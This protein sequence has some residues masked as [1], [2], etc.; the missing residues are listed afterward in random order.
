MT[1]IS[2][3]IVF[4]LMGL[5]GMV[6]WLHEFLIV[7]AGFGPICFLLGGVM[8]VLAGVSSF[9]NSSGGDKEK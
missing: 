9:Q 7:L 3:G 6:F 5:F 2:I 1:A 8:A 4:V